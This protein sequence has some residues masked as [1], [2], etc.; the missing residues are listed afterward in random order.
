MKTETQMSIRV[1]ND[2]KER[3]EKAA[4]EERRSV[5]ALMKI[6]LEDWLN[7]YEKKEE[8]K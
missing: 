1:T 5:A 2:F 8:E 4:E 3:M 7:E 6:I